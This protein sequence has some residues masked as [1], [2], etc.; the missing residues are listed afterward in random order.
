V[1]KKNKKSIIIGITALVLI[2]IT[3]LG[4]TYAYYRTRVIGNN[5]EKSIGVKV[6]KLEIV[7]SDD[8]SSIAATGIEPGYTATKTFSV[9]NT[10]DESVEFNIIFDNVENGFNKGVA[11]RGEYNDWSYKLYSGET[12]DETKVLATGE[13]TTSREQSVLEK[14]SVAS[15]EKL[16]YTLVVTY[17][18]LENIDQSDDMGQTFELRVNISENPA[19]SILWETAPQGTLIYALRNNFEVESPKSTLGSPSVAKYSDGE[20]G[21]EKNMSYATSREYWTYGTGYTFDDKTGLYTLTGVKTLSYDEMLADSGVKYLVSDSWLNNTRATSTEIIRTSNLPSI[22]FVKSIDSTNKRM[23]IQKKAANVVTLEAILSSAEDDYG[24]SYYFRGNV[25][26]NYVNFSGMCWRIVRVQGDG[27]IKIVLADEENECNNGY[28]VNNN[29]SA[30]IKN[31]DGDFVDSYMPTYYKNGFSDL[32]KYLNNDAVSSWESFK[33][34]KIIDQTKLVDSEWCLDDT[35]SDSYWEMEIDLDEDGIPETEAYT[36]WF[37][38]FDRAIPTL[39]CDIVGAHSGKS[40]K[41]R[42]KIGL[43]TKDEVMFAGGTEQ[44]L[45]YDYN[46]YL[47]TN[48]KGNYWGTLTPAVY[49]NSYAPWGFTDDNYIAVIDTYLEPIPVYSNDS[50]Q[51]PAVTLRSDVKVTLNGAG[52]PGT[53]SNPYIVG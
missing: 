50:F 26:N 31:D 32:E 53:Y 44:S 42:S 7:Y 8:N 47:T 4:L 15:G 33:N 35:I 10:G 21:T 48:T 23:S 45:E 17:A 13:I 40:T 1:E 20:L 6:K 29:T 37:S 11:T 46:Y 22:Y 19:G 14:V 41:I 3:L 43:L 16:N 12:V 2:T 36:D 28:D 30:F 39:K 25:E 24:T 5:A 18:D 34:H 38:G 9:E 49:A 27:A 51:R 52:I